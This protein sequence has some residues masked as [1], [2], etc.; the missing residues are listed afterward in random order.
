MS[1]SQSSRAE[2]TFDKQAK[3]FIVNFFDALN[4]SATIGEQQSG[5]RSKT[6]NHI[7]NCYS[8]QFNKHTERLYKNSNWP[9][10]EVILPLVNNGMLLIAVNHMFFFWCICCTTQSDLLTTHFLLLVIRS[11]IEQH[12]FAVIFCDFAMMWTK[13]KQMRI[14]VYCMTLWE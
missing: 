4:R 6:E 5:L 1:K 12:F 2:P 9:A 3:E 7:L 14:L 8:L 10:V 11:K 13:N